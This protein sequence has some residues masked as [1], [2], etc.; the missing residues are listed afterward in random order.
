MCWREVFKSI[1]LVEAFRY[2]KWRSEWTDGEGH[3]V[4]DETPIGDFAELEGE[5]GVDR[6]RCSREVRRRSFGIHHAQLWTALR[7]VV[8]GAHQSGA[9]DLTFEAVKPVV[10]S[11]G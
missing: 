3:C 6:P 5:A 9:N 4:I 1:G 7:A 11:Q 8:R 2:E 10:K